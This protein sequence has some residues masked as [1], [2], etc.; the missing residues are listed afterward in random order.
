MSEARTRASAR[1]SGGGEASAARW[2]GVTIGR[3][4]LVSVLLLALQWVAVRPALAQLNDEVPRELRGVT[5]DERLGDYVDQKARFL[6]HDGREVTL[7]DLLSDGRPVVLTLNYYKCRT[8][9]DLQL[10][11]LVSTLRALDWVPGDNYRIVTISIDEREDVELA[12]D[13]RAGY[14][15]ELGKGEVDW[16]FLVGDAASIERVADSVGFRYKYDARLDQFAHVAVLTFLSPGE[17][18]ITRYLY[19][20][21]YRPFDVK[22]AVQEAAAGEVGDPLERIIFSCFHYDPET[23]Q[24][25]L[26]A[27][28]V[29]RLGGIVTVVLLAGFLA[30][31]F[32]RERRQ[33]RRVAASRH[34]ETVR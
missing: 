18:R 20:L 13:V 22:M 25:G 9:C 23:G 4:T 2:V 7:G 26:W 21:E 16:T 3:V 15:A 8:L 31:M 10:Q 29:M 12:R 11:G 32:W 30:I 5:I 24:Y 28:G 14:L 27:F 1:R 19:G 34:A 17:G 33:R 6:R